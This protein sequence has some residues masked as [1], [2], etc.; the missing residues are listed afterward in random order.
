[1]KKRTQKYSINPKES[2][3]EEKEHKADGTNIKQII[4]CHT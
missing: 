1:M 2:T 4:T 3:K